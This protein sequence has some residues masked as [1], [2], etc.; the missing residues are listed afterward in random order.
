MLGKRA[1]PLHSLALKEDEELYGTFSLSKGED[2]I[3][4]RPKDWGST[5]QL[6]NAGN[7]WRVCASFAK[8]PAH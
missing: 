4:I 2:K 1:M 7:G 3:L 5:V 8:R 6:L